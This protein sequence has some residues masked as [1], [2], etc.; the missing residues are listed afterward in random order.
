MASLDSEYEFR[1]ANSSDTN[2]VE[3]FLYDH[4]AKDE[5]LNRA[6]NLSVVDCGTF[7]PQIVREAVSE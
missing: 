6:F 3:A 1:V 2:L 5:T 4:F 7:F